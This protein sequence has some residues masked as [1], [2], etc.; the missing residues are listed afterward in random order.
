[1]HFKVKEEVLVLYSQ[2]KIHS[3]TV[4]WFTRPTQLAISGGKHVPLEINILSTYGSKD[5]SGSDM[6]HMV[7]IIH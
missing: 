7:T 1:V 5:D 4:Q 2:M 3:M 6:A